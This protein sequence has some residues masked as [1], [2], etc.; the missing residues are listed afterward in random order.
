MQSNPHEGIHKIGS[1]RWKPHNR[2]RTIEAERWK[3]KDGSRKMESAQWNLLDGTR[4]AEFVRWSPQLVD[5]LQ[6][7][8]SSQGTPV[9][10]LQSRRSVDALPVD[11]LPVDPLPVNALQVYAQSMH[12]QLIHSTHWASTIQ[13]M[14]TNRCN[15]RLRSS[16][17]HLIN[18]INAEAPHMD[19]APGY[20]TMTPRQGTAQRHRTT[21][22]HNG[23][24]QR[25]RTTAQDQARAHHLDKKLAISELP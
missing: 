4:A 13:S 6:P 8:H 17:C 5:A 12:S 15:S 1:A 23:T 21:V 25:H 22:P 10:A 7:R 9:K 18:A 2:G 20:R 14:E 3:P 11:P 19:I 24:T 16:Q